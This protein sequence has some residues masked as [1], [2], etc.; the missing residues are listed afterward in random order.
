MEHSRAGEAQAGQEAPPEEATVAEAIA[1][2][3]GMP[4]DPDRDDD[5]RGAVE[6]QVDRVLEEVGSLEPERGA[7]VFW[8]VLVD[9]R[10]D[11]AM[12]L[13]KQLSRYPAAVLNNLREI[14]TSAM[15]LLEFAPE[16]GVDGVTGRNLVAE[17]AAR[18]FSRV[19][20]SLS[21]QD[22][23][24]YWEEDVDVSDNEAAGAAT[25]G[26]PEASRARVG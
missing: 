21:K 3:E 14:E 16:A 13:Q 25:S 10:W 11:V 8:E 22:D 7:K 5:I 17:E 6:H 4:V 1:T 9:K 26:V 2:A 23:A 15:A 12:A 24:Q 18:I 19:R 20:L